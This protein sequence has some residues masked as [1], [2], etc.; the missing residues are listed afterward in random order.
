MRGITRF[1]TTSTCTGAPGFTSWNAIT[2]LSSW[3]IR[4]GISRAAIFSKI[5]IRHWM[6]AELRSLNTAPTLVRRGSLPPTRLGG[7]SDHTHAHTD[8]AYL[9]FASTQ[10]WDVPSETRRRSEERRVGKECR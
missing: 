4:A 2:S 8:R 10:L 6:A 3:T 1:G 5:V 9:R 7:Q